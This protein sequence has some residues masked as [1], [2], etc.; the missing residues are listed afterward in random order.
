LYIELCLHAKVRFQIGFLKISSEWVK[1]DF[2]DFLMNKSFKEKQNDSL[3]GF[4]DEKGG[5]S[6]ASVCLFSVN[7]KVYRVSN[8]FHDNQSNKSG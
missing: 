7:S 6:D 2:T 3:F 1:V 4:D 5:K 8:G